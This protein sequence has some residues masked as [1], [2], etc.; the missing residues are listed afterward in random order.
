MKVG[1]RKA[2]KRYLKG[3]SVL[4]TSQ[5]WVLMPKSFLAH[6]PLRLGLLLSTGGSQCVFSPLLQEGDS[7]PDAQREASR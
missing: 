4:Q 1:F 3:W 2:S 6:L 7:F 5:K